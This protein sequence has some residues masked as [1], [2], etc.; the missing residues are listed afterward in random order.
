LRHV[1]LAGQSQA[2]D[3]LFQVFA[4]MANLVHLLADFDEGRKG[5]GEVADDG[6]IL[7]DDSG[8]DSRA[9]DN[10][11]EPSAPHDQLLSGVT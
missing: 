11:D 1:F 10:Q 5:A 9:K 2:L 8:D 4:E 6:Q 7:T 3:V